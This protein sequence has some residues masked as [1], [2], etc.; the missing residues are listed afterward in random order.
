MRL[1]CFLLGLWIGSAYARRD[2]PD[3]LKRRRLSTLDRGRRV[4]CDLAAFG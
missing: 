1:A 4:E 3:T 2:E